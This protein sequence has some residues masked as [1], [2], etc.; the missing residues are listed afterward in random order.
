MTAPVPPE[1][2]VASAAA[3]VRLFLVALP[4]AVLAGVLAAPAFAQAAPSA[5]ALYEHYFPAADRVAKCQGLDGDQTA[6]DVRD[7]AAADPAA[8]VAYFCN[9]REASNE[10]DKGD[11]CYLR[12]DGD[13]AAGIAGLRTVGGFTF[14]AADVHPPPPVCSEMFPPCRDWTGAPDNAQ[15]PFTDTCDGARPDPPQVTVFISPPANGTVSAEWSG[16]SDLQNEETV[17]AGTTVT[18]TATPDDDYELSRWTGACTGELAS[19]LKCAVVVTADVTVG[20]DFAAPF[21]VSIFITDSPD[22]TVSAA[23]AADPEILSGETV[24][25]GAAVTFTARP[26]ADHSAARWTG[27]CAGDSIGDL[28]CVLAPTAHATVGAD[29]VFTP[30]SVAVFITDSPDGTVF[31]ASAAD[32]EILSGEI[33]AASA[34]VTFTA[35]PAN[36]YELARWTGDCAGDAD[37]DSQCAIAPTLNATVGADFAFIAAP[38]TP[39]PEF[40]DPESAEATNLRLLCDPFSTGDEGY[41]FID[42]QGGRH[43]QPFGIVPTGKTG[44]VCNL[45]QPLVHPASGAM[46]ASCFFQHDSGF[47]RNLLILAHQQH[48]GAPDCGDLIPHCPEARKTVPGNPFS[49]CRSCESENRWESYPECGPCLPGAELRDGGCVVEWTVAFSSG[50][51][52]TVF[53]GLTDGAAVAAGGLVMDGA[54]VTF[55]AM[56]DDGAEFSMWGG[57][58]AEFSGPACALTVRTDVSVGADFDCLD[59]HGAGQSFASVKCN[60]AAG[61][62]ADGRDGLGSTP[63]HWAAFNGL[64]L[65]VSLLLSRDADVNA[66]DNLGRTPLHDAAGSVGY[67]SPEVVRLLLSASPAPSLN[68]RAGDGETPLTKAAAAGKVEIFKL[69]VAA[70]GRHAGAECGASEVPNPEGDDPPCVSDSCEAGEVRNDLVCES[71]GLRSAPNPAADACV[72]EDAAH[73]MLNGHCVHPEERLSEGEE[74]CATVF[75]GDWVDLS[76]EHGAGKG[77]CSGIDIN[78]TFCLAGTVSALPCLGLFNHVRTCNLLGRPALDPWHCGAACAGGQAAGARCLE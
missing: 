18:F 57:A 15:N 30:A 19:E 53:A 20:A 9:T 29:F 65:A 75:G 63:L 12:K 64:P 6:V 31:A 14:Q 45:P 27:D 40:P 56:A 28:Q 47:N 48:Q 71:C 5:A 4:T 26:D 36:G 2:V 35:A 1:S 17:P 24:S 69:L 59:F 58:C 76:A 32:P 49:A 51:S 16:D 77:V 21:P 62:D 8:N 61:A 33:V 3:A 74:T 50:P 43:Q 10:E 22:G 46:R 39:N 34:A 54:T 11:V 73:R 44:S 23:S 67:G 13:H 38:G 25:F 70:G 55:S 60:L 68:V 7:P 37:G 66:L 41:N 52:G 42:A 78:D 72:C